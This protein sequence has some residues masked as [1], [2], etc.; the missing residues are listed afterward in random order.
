M[1]VDDGEFKLGLGGA[2]MFGPFLEMTGE[3]GIR[4]DVDAVNLSD[5]REIIED[6]L[7]HRLARDGQKW[8]GLRE[9]EGIEA[10]GVSGG[11]DD[12]FHILN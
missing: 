1:V 12:D 8:F 9:G 7:D 3:L 10:R 6:V 4:D 11:K 5:G 2:V